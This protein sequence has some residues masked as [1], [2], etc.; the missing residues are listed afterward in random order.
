MN[1]ETLD[2]EWLNR[3]KRLRRD[4][5]SEDPMVALSARCHLA[6]EEPLLKWM[7]DEFE[8]G[9]TDLE[10]MA[11]LLQLYSVHFAHLLYT[12]YGDDALTE[13]ILKDHADSFRKI[14]ADQ[15]MIIQKS[16][17]SGHAT[18]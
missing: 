10:I 13:V 6:G 17:N 16:I 18:H 3:K 2:A 11:T 5:K 4:L 1:R 12:I 9:A 7:W 14:L 8:N 15:L